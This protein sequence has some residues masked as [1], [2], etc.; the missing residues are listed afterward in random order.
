MKKGL[1]VS[2]VLMLPMS[3][4][5]STELIYTWGY[6]ESFYEAL[7]ALK[8]FTSEADYLVK[9]ALAIA[10]FVFSIGKALDSKSSPVFEIGKLF[11]LYGVVYY[12][13]LSP[14]NNTYIIHDEVTSKDYKVS[15]LPMG[16]GNT[17][18]LMSRLEKTILDGMEKHYSTPNSISYSKAGLGFSLNAMMDIPTLR[19]SEFDRELQINMDYYV[20]NCFQHNMG[21]KIPYNSLNKNSD[22]LN[23]VLIENDGKL[24]YFTKNGV[25]KIMSCGKIAK[26]IKTAFIAVVGDASNKVASKNAIS[27]AINQVEYLNKFQAASSLYF[28]Q[29]AGAREQFQ[30]IML[31][32]SLDDGIINTAKMLGLNP[33]SFAANTAIADQTITASMQAQGRLAQ[34]YLPLAKA[35]MTIIVV[36]VSWLMAI[37][38]IIFGS[39]TH[40]K[41]FFTLCLTMVLWTPILSLINFLNDLNIQK[42]FELVNAN[43]AAFTYANYKDVIQKIT[44]NSN[45]LSYLIMLTPMLAFAL[46]KGSEMGFVSIASSLSQQLA[47]GAR[48]AGSFATQQALSTSTA[49]TTPRGDE[50]YAKE[51]GVFSHLGSYYDSNGNL[52]TYSTKTNGYSGVYNSQITNSIMSGTNVGG[53]IQ[54]AKLNDAA[55]D[56]LNSFEQ[57]VANNY[58]QQLNEAFSKMSEKGKTSALSV[59]RQFIESHDEAFTKQFST[60]LAQEVAVSDQTTKSANAKI[61]AYAEAHAGASF[62]GSGVSAGVRGEIDTQTASIMNLT[63][64]ERVAYNEAV[65]RASVKTVTESDSASATY[66]ETLGIKDA[67]TFSQMKTISQN[68]AETQ[69]SIQS[70]K[71]NDL[72]NIINGVAQNMAANNGENWNSLSVAQQ[73]KYFTDAGSHIN[74]LAQSNPAALQGLQK[75]YGAGGTTQG[76]KFNLN[77]TVGADVRGHNNQKIN[78]VNSE[79][80]MTSQGVLII[81]Q[82]TLRSEEGGFNEKTKNVSDKYNSANI[83]KKGA[84][85][86]AFGSH[87]SII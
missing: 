7:Q 33:Q 54:G 24:G 13:F 75:Q 47:G 87:G 38:S 77:N 56:N 37:I 81:D 79:Y 2:I 41:M 27:T 74:N 59:A 50:V 19:V 15:K 80:S 1:I 76:E 72:N 35:Y 40:I 46:A 44:A 6:G 57:Q 49:I 4:F 66:T 58:S 61:S 67:H 42:S 36:S 64:S 8:G 52:T 53:S 55:I 45:F 18:S 20:R 83:L 29:A 51:A 65:S 25:S 39:Y 70:V 78:Q 68:Y 28:R 31:M 10:V 69:S 86:I 9:M 22:L 48:A 14:S 60:N 17:V 5:G 71:G 82:D 11:M 23:V 34:T 43:D 12:F 30:Q 26:E 63:E 62:M 32:N 73:N 21:T 3:V 84:N 16:I 85:N